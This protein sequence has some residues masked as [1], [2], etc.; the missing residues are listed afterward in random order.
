[1]RGDNALYA[2]W[3]EAKR[4]SPPTFGELR[5]CKMEA[6]GGSDWHETSGG[7]NKERKRLG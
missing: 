5:M 2:A 4:V 6:I 7:E 3:E 1:M